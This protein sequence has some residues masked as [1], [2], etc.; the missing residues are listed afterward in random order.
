MKKT[1]ELKKDRSFDIATRWGLN[2]AGFERAHR[3]RFAQVVDN[4]ERPTERWA[5]V[6]LEVDTKVRQ[7]PLTCGLASGHGDEPL[8]NVRPVTKIKAS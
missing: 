2:R 7:L 8:Q 4:V 6:T 3:I 5:D 1:L